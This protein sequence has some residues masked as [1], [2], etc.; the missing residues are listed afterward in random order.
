MHDPFV[1]AF[2]I[3]RPWPKRRDSDGW[4]YW[5]SVIVIW[6]REPR[7][8]DSGEICRHYRYDPETGRATI[9][10]A[11]RWHIHHWRIQV[12]PLQVLRWLALTRCAWCG[13]RSRRRDPVDWLHEQGLYHG[14]CSAAYIA[15]KTCLCVYP[16]LKH[17]GWGH[18][19]WCGNFRPYG[20]SAEA[21]EVRR[22]HASCEIGVRPTPANP[23]E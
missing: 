7:G 18:C 15:H 9:L 11:W 8:H 2:K 22:R 23:G 3:K 12:P 1:V 6:H 20:L 14:D 5:P 21:L 13:G 4:C 19:S 10:H 16:T 17:E